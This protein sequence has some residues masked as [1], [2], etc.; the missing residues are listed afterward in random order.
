MSNY[1]VKIVGVGEESDAGILDTLD[2]AQ[3]DAEQEGAQVRVSFRWGAEQLAIV[4]EAARL[5][6]LPRDV[7]IKKALFDRASAD[8][9]AHNQ[10]EAGRRGEQAA[11]SGR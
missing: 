7:C 6:G 4:E 9:A 10:L 3:R 8:L 1:D 11:L 5:Q 2:Q